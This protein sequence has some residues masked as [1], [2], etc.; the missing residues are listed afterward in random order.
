MDMS[1]AQ[2]L[3]DFH[4]ARIFEGVTNGLYVDVGGGHPVAD[5]VTFWFYIQGWRGLVVEPQAKLAQL[6]RRLRPRDVVVETLV[7]RAPGE[8]AF[9][10]VE[11]MHGFSTMV[12]QHA[13]AAVAGG[14][15]T[16]VETKPVET[17]AALMDR[18]LPGRADVLKIDVEGA[19]ADV[20][21][22]A[23]LARLRPRV[24]VV[25]AVA[26]G[27]M[28]PA[29]HDWEPMILG[30]GYA[31]MLFDGL[32]RFY[33]A[34]EETE[35][36]ARFPREP[37]PWNAVAHLYD[38]G[39]APERPDHPDHALA[40]ALV[41]GFLAMLPELDPRLLSDILVRGLTERALEGH[42][43]DIDG[44]SIGSDAARAALGRIACMYDGGH[45]VE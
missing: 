45:L 26:P 15:A 20:I 41:H 32:N 11:R 44:D 5:N 22:G 34:N 1:Y 4:L 37:A 14:A 6:T 43:A 29:W 3:E 30:A 38:A 7:G 25:E 27:S 2:R 31:M 36:F 12:A 40:R 33:L 42:P 23:D 13:D 9:H 19:E 24:I 17:L 16:H 35:L 18:H 39:R 28:A 8:A 10:Q 21:A